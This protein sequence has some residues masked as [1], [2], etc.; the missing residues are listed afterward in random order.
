VPEV[1]RVIAGAVI[2]LGA[3]AVFAVMIV[4]SR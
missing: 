1:A 4:S 3:L 2:G